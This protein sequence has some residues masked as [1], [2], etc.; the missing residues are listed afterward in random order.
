MITPASVPVRTMIPAQLSVSVEEATSYSSA[1]TYAYVEPIAYLDFAGRID[2]LESG[3][4]VGAGGDHRWDAPEP[5]AYV[6]GGTR[7]AA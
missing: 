1:L 5:P 4:G 7:L 6:T 3:Y 2:W